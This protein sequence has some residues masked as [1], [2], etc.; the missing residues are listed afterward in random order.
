MKQKL[1]LLLFS[2]LVSV[3]VFAGDDDQLVTRDGTITPVKIVKISTQEVTYID[4]SKKKRQRTAATSFV[5]MI[6]KEKG[7]NIFFDE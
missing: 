2:L 5:Y 7:N 3:N 6:M 1:L 4:L